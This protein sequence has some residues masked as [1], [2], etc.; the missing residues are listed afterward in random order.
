[1]RPRARS[2][3]ADAGLP[4][5]IDWTDRTGW[6][7]PRGCGATHKLIGYDE[8]G[9]GLSPRMRGYLTLSAR[10]LTFG[11]SIPADAGLPLRSHERGAQPTVYPR[12]CGATS[13][14]SR[15]VSSVRGLSPRMRGYLRVLLRWS[16]GWRSIPADA[17]LPCGFESHPW[18]HMV[19]PRGCG[20]TL[21]AQY[22]ASGRSGLS[23]RMRGYPRK[24]RVEKRLVRSIPADAGLPA[25]HYSAG[26]DKGVYPRGCGATPPPDGPAWNVVGLSPRMRGY[27]YNDDVRDTDSRS[28]PADAGLP[29]W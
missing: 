6:V 13:A 27:L 24:I 20:A 17:G 2:I 9:E 3:P 23:P 11:R 28:I 16:A 10:S 21:P 4:C 12:G 19:Y 7:Y 25:S 5:V 15:T 1:M 22:Q 29:P 18:P 26:A 14:V 8:G